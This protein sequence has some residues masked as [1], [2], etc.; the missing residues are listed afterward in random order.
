MIFKCANICAL[1]SYKCLHFFRKVKNS[2][3]KETPPTQT[4]ELAIIQGTDTGGK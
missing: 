4:K 2:V 1:R 3:K